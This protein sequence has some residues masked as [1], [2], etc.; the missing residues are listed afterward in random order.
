MFLSLW[1]LIFIE[2]TLKCEFHKNKE[3]RCPQSAPLALET[4]C[5]KK[6]G[7]S[8]TTETSK[9]HA[10]TQFWSLFTSTCPPRTLTHTEPPHEIAHKE[11]LDTMKEPTAVSQKKTDGLLI[12]GTYGSDLTPLHFPCLSCMPLPAYLKA[13]WSQWCDN[14]WCWCCRTETAVWQWHY[15]TD[16]MDYEQ[17]HWAEFES[18]DPFHC[19]NVPSAYWEMSTWA[20]CCSV[21]VIL[22]HNTFRRTHAACSSLLALRLASPSKTPR[23]LFAWCCDQSSVGPELPTLQVPQTITRR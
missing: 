8:S 4:T 17:D 2:K 11:I 9:L 23:S 1:V 14:T 22:G 15:I 7:T 13:V 5:T 18:S 10:L 6:N 20:S 21:S 3:S 12:T 19:A 16:N